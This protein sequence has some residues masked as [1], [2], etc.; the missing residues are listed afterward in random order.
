ME[1]DK[2]Q[3]MKVMT[4]LKKRDLSG[5]KVLVRV[6]FNVPIKEGRVLDD[7]RLKQSLPTINYLLENEAKVILISHLG[8]NNAS[9]TPIVQHLN[10]FIDIRLVED[11]ISKDI[12]FSFSNNPN[13]VILLE[14]IRRFEGEKNNDPEFAKQLA[15]L[16]DIYVN[17]AFSVSHRAHASVVAITKYLPSYA[18]LLFE[19]EFKNLDLVLHSSGGKMVVI[20]GGLKFKTKIPLVEQFIDA[21]SH[22]FIGGALA[23]S[24]M[25]ALGQDIGA[26]VADEQTDYL[27]PFLKNKK[28]ILPVDWVENSQE[29][30]V[31]I[32]PKSLDQIKEMIKSADIVLWNGPL[33]LFE[34]GFKEGTL[35]LAKIIA[36]NCVADSSNQRNCFSVVGGGDTLS[37]I[38]ELS[39]EDKFGFIST[40]GGA[41][42]DF[43]AKGTLP[44][45]E[46]LE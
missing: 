9:L 34:A 1:L 27:I 10:N 4:Q 35:A 38:Q 17:D 32:G 20:L 42:L 39:L 14:N 46:A 11:F 3:K 22:I 6:D 18:G 12:D 29:Q 36:Q 24:F 13:Q 8:D 2:S 41:M 5:K 7:F 25:K 44:G 21:A 26:S 19:R 28:I 45:L 43:L 23:N 30:I 15:E 33:G 16:G 31:D 40:A 37:A